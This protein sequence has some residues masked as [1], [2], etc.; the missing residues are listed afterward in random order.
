[1]TEFGNINITGLTG[2]ICRVIRDIDTL[3]LGSIGI[4]VISGLAKGIDSYAPT[5]C[6]KASGFTAAV[7]GCGIDVCYPVEHNSRELPSSCS[8]GP[9]AR[10]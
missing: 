9:R 5:A 10:G 2:F 1:M 3:Y 6:I 8:Q 7:L 4:P